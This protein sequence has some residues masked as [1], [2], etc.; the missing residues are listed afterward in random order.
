[1]PED[2]ENLYTEDA[3]EDYNGPKDKKTGQ[4][5]YGKK[6]PDG[7][8]L[9]RQQRLYRRQLEG[10][11]ARQLVLDHA[12]REGISTATAWRDWDT[13]SQW[14]TA[15]WDAERET[16]LSRINGMRLRVIDKAIRRGQLST[17]QALLADL[18]RAAGEGS[19]FMA[20]EQ[21]PQLNITVEMP[22]A[23]P[24]GTK[25]PAIEPA[26]VIELE[27]ES[28]PLDEGDIL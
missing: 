12:S 14:N 6:N 2:K 28:A 25:K 24:E 22:G 15:D 19:E 27:A 11:P 21:A 8:I 17:A 5:V 16:I 4:R 9:E 18:G 23:L 13:V 1:M 20:A 3:P 7:W 26:E 10:L